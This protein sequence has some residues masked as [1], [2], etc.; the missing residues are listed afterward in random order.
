MIGSKII[1]RK[2]VKFMKIK[3]FSSSN[4]ETLENNVNE[5]LK[6]AEIEIVD[7]K[8]STDSNFSNVMIIYNDKSEC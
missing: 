3:L 5:F 1:K 2:E 4:N 6:F 8:F 7:I